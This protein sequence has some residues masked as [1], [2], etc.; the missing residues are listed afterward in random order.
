MATARKSAGRLSPAEAARQALDRLPLQVMGEQDRADVLAVLSNV[1]I[2]HQMP[3]RTIECSPDFYRFLVEHPDVIVSVWQ[4]LGITQL[5]VAVDDASVFHINDHQGTTAVARFLYRSPSLHVIYTEGAYDGA[6]LPKP[7][8]G[9]TL[10]LLNSSYIRDAEGRA[11]V[12]CRL[13]VFMQVERKGVA[14]IAKALYPLV[15]GMAETNYTQTV[16]FLNWLNRAAREKPGA[17]LRLAANLEN[18]SDET[19]QTFSNYLSAIA[20]PP[21][22]GTSPLPQ[23]AESGTDLP[24]PIETLPQARITTD[25]AASTEAPSV[26]LR[27]RVIPD[28]AERPTRETI[29]R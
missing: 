4:I 19:R 11:L 23:T 15:A 12:M 17:M 8:R 27:L 24:L 3:I 1:T 25:A 10:L 21:E 7:V 29:E 6:L 9:R 26:E 14:L 2:Y 28:S 13:E 22:A 18:V 20:L 16:G 5:E